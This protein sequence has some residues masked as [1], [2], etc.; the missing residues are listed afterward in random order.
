[1]TK[2]GVFAA[3]LA[4]T[5]LVAVAETNAPYVSVVTGKPVTADSPYTEE[6][7]RARDER[8]M[9]KTGGF[10]Q[11]EAQGPVA[12]VAD[13]RAKNAGTIDEVARLYTLGTKLAMGTGREPLGGRG[14]LAYGRALV[15]D[16]G[17]LMAVFVID[18]DE[19][20]W[21]ALSV[22]PEERF[23]FVNAARLKGGEDPTALEMRVAKELWR[24]I[25]FI[26][27]VGFSA[28]DN[29]VMRPYYTLGE[30]DANTH[31]YIQPMNMAKMGLF[32]QRF[33]VRRARRVPYRAAVKEG[34]AQPPTNDYQR[35]VW[36]EEK[37]NANDA[38]TPAAK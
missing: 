29:D 5:A 25:G 12:M 30:L 31:P 6:Q 26:G 7:I 35:A 21:P 32:W 10:L 27:G 18:D 14:P 36:N 38:N 16:G 1:M 34:W 24:A 13:T 9:K 33:G 3:V 17:A 8:V 11:I 28:Q 20:G 23:G 2:T 37:A 15:A 4:C 22:F 19:G